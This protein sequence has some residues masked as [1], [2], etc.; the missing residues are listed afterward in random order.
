MR[1]PMAEN[2]AKLREMVGRGLRLAPD[3]PGLLALSAHL[4]RYDGDIKL[5]EQRFATARQKDPSNRIRSKSC[6]RFSNSIRATPTK[7]SR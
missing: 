4:A 6:T 5:A 1:V 3:D 7:R 2:R